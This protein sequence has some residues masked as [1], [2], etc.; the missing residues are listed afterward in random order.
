[1]PWAKRGTVTATPD[2][3]VAATQTPAATPSPAQTLPDAPVPGNTTPTWLTVI[4]GVFC[5]ASAALAVVF[6][7]GLVWLVR[8][9]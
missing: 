4:G 8:Q 3:Q 2:A 5:C 6:L 9:F 1:V 7:V